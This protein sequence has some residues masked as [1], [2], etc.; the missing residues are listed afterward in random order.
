MLC[1]IADPPVSIIKIEG[2][3]GYMWPRQ[4][5]AEVVGV[6]SREVPKKFVHLTHERPDVHLCQ[7]LYS[8]VF[9][10]IGED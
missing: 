9:Y 4:R 3:Q 2:L 7:V 5:Y 1:M 10:T 8:K 6:Q